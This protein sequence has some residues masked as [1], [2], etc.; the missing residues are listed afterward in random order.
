MTHI[1]DEHADMTDSD[2]ESKRSDLSPTHVVKSNDPSPSQLSEAAAWEVIGRP[3][4]LYSE[5][6][7]QGVLFGELALPPTPDMATDTPSLRTLGIERPHPF[8][9]HLLAYR[10]ARGAA[11]DL[12]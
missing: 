2:Y 8:L 11:G 3:V 6:E 10:D 5:R 7:L 4:D 1:V 12:G 9:T